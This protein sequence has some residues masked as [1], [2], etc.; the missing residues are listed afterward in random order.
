MQEPILNPMYSPKTYT[1]IAMAYT[2][3]IISAYESDDTIEIVSLMPS[4]LRHIYK[5][6]G[7]NFNEQSEVSLFYTLYQGELNFKKTDIKDI[8][9][10]YLLAN[11]PLVYAE[12]Q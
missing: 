5:L 2:T 1:S 9:R 11:A 6:A 12:N 4:E 10:S 3:A 8:A 7:Y